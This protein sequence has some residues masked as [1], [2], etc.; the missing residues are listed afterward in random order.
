MFQL[1]KFHC[2]QQGVILRAFRF[3]HCHYNHVTPTKLGKIIFFTPIMFPTILQVIQIFYFCCNL[4]TPCPKMCFFFLPF[5]I[6]GSWLRCVKLTQSW[7]SSSMM[8]FLPFF[9]MDACQ[10]GSTN[11]VTRVASTTWMLM[12]CQHD[13]INLPLRSI[14]GSIFYYKI[15]NEIKFYKD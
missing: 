15:S 11:D 9:D 3:I 1:V 12:H 2:L 10:L 8:K 6:F 5:L 4:Q 14:C 7:H 13:V